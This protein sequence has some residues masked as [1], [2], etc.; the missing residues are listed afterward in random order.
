MLIVN[1]ILLKNRNFARTK[2]ILVIR[3]CYLPCRAR[4][5]SLGHL[6]RML[7]SG[8]PLMFELWGA[9]KDLSPTDL[10]LSLSCELR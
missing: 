1:L 7:G 4:F 3:Q 6:C 10:R 5:N 9:H 8:R 2:I